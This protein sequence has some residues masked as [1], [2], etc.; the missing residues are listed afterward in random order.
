MN[1]VSCAATYPLLFVAAEQPAGR[2]LLSFRNYS[3]YEAEGKGML[4]LGASCAFLGVILDDLGRGVTLA[5]AFIV[6]V[7]VWI[8]P[9]MLALAVD[10]KARYQRRA[11]PGA[12]R[13]VRQ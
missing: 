11:F 13:V 8:L 6:S 12:S 7:F 2:L 4:F 3:V 5:G 10:S 9:A 1:F